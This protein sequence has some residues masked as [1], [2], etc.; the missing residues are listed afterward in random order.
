MKKTWWILLIILF[1]IIYPLFACSEDIEDLCKD[2]YAVIL[3]TNI[4]DDFEGCD[5]DKCYKLDNGAIF[6]CNHYSYHYAYHPE[7]YAL[8]H[9]RTGA[10]K[11]IID[12]EEFSGNLYKR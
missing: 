5:Y 10:I 6:K 1:I 4:S 3:E 2:G 7:F 11:Y 12:N 8:Q 9:I